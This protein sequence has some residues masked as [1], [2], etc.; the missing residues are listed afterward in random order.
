M[1]KF[2]MALVF[3]LSA[4]LAVGGVLVQHPMP[5]GLAPG[6]YSDIVIAQ[7]EGADR[8]AG[9]KSATP[10]ATSKSAP[11]AATMKPTTPAQGSQGDMSKG[12]TKGN[13]SPSP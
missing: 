7:A 9:E 3:S 12:N 1:Q 6:A 4:T 11:E 5:K 2:S 10:T 13:P 8:P